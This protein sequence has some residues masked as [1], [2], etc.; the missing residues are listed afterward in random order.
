MSDP[1]LIAGPAMSTAAAA[2]GAPEESNAMAIGISK[3]VGSATST[4][5]VATNIPPTS[6]LLHTPMSGITELEASTPTA[7]NGIVI[8]ATL[9]AFFANSLITVTTVHGS[10]EE[11][12]A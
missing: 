4:V 3:N 5:I 6:P 10:V 12:A 7:I 9:K 1:A 2:A 11:T 8:S